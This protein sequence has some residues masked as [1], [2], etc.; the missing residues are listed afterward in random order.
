MCQLE[1]CKYFHLVKKPSYLY[2]WN[3]LRLVQYN[4]KCTRNNAFHQREYPHT[5]M[6]TPKACIMIF[7]NYTVVLTHKKAKN[8]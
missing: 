5:P 1:W 4:A 7:L 6:C 2:L 8:E 3:A